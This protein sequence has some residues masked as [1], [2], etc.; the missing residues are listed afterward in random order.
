[1]GRPDAAG[2]EDKV[3]A[4]PAFVDRG[5]A[6]TRRRGETRANV[7]LA[8]ANGISTLRL[9]WHWAIMRRRWGCGVVPVPCWGGCRSCCRASWRGELSQC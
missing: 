3:V 4:L 9:A 8:I 1:M 2:G 6:H 7:G 5:H